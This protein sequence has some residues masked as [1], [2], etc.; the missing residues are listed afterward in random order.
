VFLIE[1]GPGVETK[2]IKTSYSATAGTAYVTFDNV[3][4]PV[5]NMLGPDGG[6]IFVMLRLAGLLT[7]LG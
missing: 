4:V 5:G 2:P 7:E 6:G 1:R 3:K